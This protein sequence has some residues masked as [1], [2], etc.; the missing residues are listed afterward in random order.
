MTEDFSLFAFT[1]LLC[2]PTDLN[3][4]CT[5]KR[6]DPNKIEKHLIDKLGFSVSDA[7]RLMKKLDKKQLFP[8]L[9]LIAALAQTLQSVVP[10]YAGGGA[11]PPG[12]VAKEIVRRL[13]KG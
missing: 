8:H 5:E 10:E 12:T 11:H 7:K 6:F 2:T 13:T 1:L 4:L 3:A 9:P